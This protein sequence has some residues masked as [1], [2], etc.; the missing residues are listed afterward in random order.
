M[1]VNWKFSRDPVLWL[2]LAAMFI[3]GISTWLVPLSDGQQALLNGFL[4]G[5][6]N[7]WAAFKVGDGQVAAI[8]GVFKAGLAVA[9]G[10]GLRMSPEEQAV[11]LG[12]VTTVL[13]VVTR[14]QVV[15]MIPGPLPPATVGPH[16]GR[17]TPTAPGFPRAG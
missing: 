1:K 2:N 5:V 14:S 4:L 6:A 13:M 11:A 12:I 17:S 8:M 7:V 16:P 3:M 15:S 10:F 9:L